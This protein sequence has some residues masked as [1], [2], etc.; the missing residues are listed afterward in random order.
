MKRLPALLLAVALVHAA[1]AQGQTPCPTNSLS[2]HVDP[3]APIDLS[4]SA[5]RDS[6]RN[7]YEDCPDPNFPCTTCIAS[8]SYDLSL[9]VLHAD[10]FILGGCSSYASVT[11]HD[12][13]TLSGPP[14]PTPISFVAR[15]SFGL[16][17]SC[18]Y[19]G[20]GAMGVTL[21]GTGG[22]SAGAMVFCGE[23]YSGPPSLD[24]VISC[25]PGATFDIDMGA[26]ANAGVGPSSVSAG[27]SL[28]FPDLPA[29]YSVISCQG[30]MA[31]QVVPA[32]TTSWGSLKSMY[33]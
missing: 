5:P 31:G 20:D 32:R 14:S 15:G 26:W 3:V 1:S 30:F 6:A 25:L 22:T 23:P 13:F 11:T 10:A 9:G 17:G 4:S 2:A 18:L 24:V 21:H 19:P 28:G 29:G 27:L 8:A 16:S 7:S 33:R 12:V